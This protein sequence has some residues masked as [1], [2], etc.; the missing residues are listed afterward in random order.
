MLTYIDS[1]LPSPLR[2]Y[3]MYSCWQDNIFHC[4]WS[5]KLHEQK[6]VFVVYHYHNMG[7]MDVDISKKKTNII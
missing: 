3:D 1:S 7:D 6:I 4:S 2:I 5:S